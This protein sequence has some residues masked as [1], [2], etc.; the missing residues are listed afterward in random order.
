MSDSNK[1]IAAETI[2]AQALGLEDEATGA[3][4]RPVHVSTTF[5]RHPDYEL[6]DGRSYMRDH[7]PTQAHAESIVCRLEG[8]VDA[9][10]FSSGMAACTAPFHALNKGDHALV[11]DT[12]YHGVLSWLHEFAE[13]RGISYQL[14]AAGDLDALKNGLESRD[15]ALVW[16]ETPANPSWA[17]TD[18]RA[19][20]DLAHQYGA[21]VAVDSTAATPVHTQPIALGADIVCHSATKFLNGHTDVVAGVLVTAND[22]AYWQRIRKHRLLGGAVLS[23]MDAHLLI[24]GMRTLYLRVRQQSQSALQ[25]AE[26]LQA[27][28]A[29]ETVLYPGLQSHPGHD[30]AVRQMQDGFGGML[31][32]LIPGSKTEVIQCLSKAKVF[33]RATS[34]GGVESLMEHRKSSESD[35]TRTPDNL[36]RMSTGIERVDDLIADLDQ[37]LS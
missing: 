5:A 23:S 36:I 32:F 29:V 10:T 7:G 19:C 20:C 28:N 8:G 37:M 30:I 15:A 26:F 21:L 17:V 16:L 33:K 2:A 3:I 27:H 18:I 9:L 35:V 34:L 24:R 14:F 1:L 22:S 12:I 11:S 25:I 13:S 6:P 31:S 4:I